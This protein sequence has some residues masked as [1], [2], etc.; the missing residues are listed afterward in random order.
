[1]GDFGSAKRINNKHP[2][3]EYISTRWYRAPECLLTDGYYNFPMDL[4]SVGCCMYEVMWYVN[5]LLLIQLIYN[6][7]FKIR[8]LNNSLSPLF[9]GANEIDQIDKIHD[10]LGTP[11]RYLLEKFKK[12]SRMI[13]FDFKPKKGVGIGRYMQSFPRE[14]IDLIY[15]LCTYDPE[16]RINAH[17]ALKHQYFILY[18]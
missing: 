13:R 14:A 4:W 8:L 12:Q 10:I 15:L 5:N 3:T 11:D 9:P 16:H 2:F 7:N 6:L 17:K 18:K 1:M